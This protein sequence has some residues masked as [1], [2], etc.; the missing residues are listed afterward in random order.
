MQ[1]CTNCGK[2]LDDDA[3][4]CSR[5]GKAINSN[6]SNESKRKIEY[7][8]TIHKC[9]NCGEILDAFTVKCP[10]CNYEIRNALVT[11]SIK[12]F[13]Y[14]LETANSDSD[15]ATIIRHFPIPNDK[16][17]ILEFLIL[18]ASNADKKIDSEISEAWLVK[19]DQVMR[20][21]KILFDENESL[22]I[23]KQYDEILKKLKKEKSIKNVKKFGV[24]AAELIPILPQFISIFIWIL[25][26]MILMPKCRIG[27]DNVGTNSY[28]WILMIVYI[29]GAVFVPLVL[30]C[31]SVLP[32]LEAV[33][34]VVLSIVL[35]MPL[36]KENL[37][38]VGTN[39]FLIS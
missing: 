6:T 20:K 33:A 3:K 29:A 36:L 28:Q 32:K 7:N 37:D 13:S 35:M 5:C 15:K 31:D 11:E 10:S 14:K 9:P 2:Q 26:M 8:G 19:L 30:R 12:E 24:A 39:A 27:L 21:A 17:D 18:A 4:F 16:E 22:K 25:C 1:Y 23:K 34:G 38:N